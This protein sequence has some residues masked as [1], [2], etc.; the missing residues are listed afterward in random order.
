MTIRILSQSFSFERS[1][2]E[3]LVL[4]IFISCGILI[5]ALMN[6]ENLREYNK[7]YPTSLHETTTSAV[8]FFDAGTTPRLI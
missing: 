5:I 2:C 7:Y 1:K 3:L 8:L 6:V 4:V